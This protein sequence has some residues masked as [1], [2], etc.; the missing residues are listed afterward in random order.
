MAFLGLCEKLESQIVWRHSEVH[1]LGGRGWFG[2]WEEGLLSDEHGNRELRNR[3]LSIQQGFCGSG[4]PGTV[5]WCRSAEEWGV[6]ANKDRRSLQRIIF[7]LIRT[8]VSKQR[9]EGLTGAGNLALGISR[10][11]DC[12]RFSI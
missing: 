7:P 4:I 12:P 10:A 9:K 1:M 8:M 3:E 11:I 5:L 2:F 6:W